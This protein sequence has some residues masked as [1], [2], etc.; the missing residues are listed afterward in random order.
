MQTAA[1]GSSRRFEKAGRLHLRTN[2]HK[3]HGR[4]RA[5]EYDELAVCDKLNL[6]LQWPR[7]SASEDSASLLKQEGLA[8]VIVEDL[9]SAL[10]AFQSIAEDLEVAG[11]AAG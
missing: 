1:S 4:W 8:A 6:D 2:P 3:Q 9:H 5:L 7:D 10:V 11:E